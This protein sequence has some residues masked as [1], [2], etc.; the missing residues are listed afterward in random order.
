MKEIFN[1]QG[2]CLFKT[3]PSYFLSEEEKHYI[4]NLEYNNTDNIH[5]ISKNVNILNNPLCDNLNN[6]LN[7]YANYYIKN[8]LEIDHKLKQLNSWVTINKKGGY[9]PIHNHTNTFISVCFYP[10][11]DKGGISFESIPPLQNKTNLTFKEI[12]ANVFNSNKLTLHFSS[13]DLIIF[14]GWLDHSGEIND[15]NIDR[16]MIG[17]NYFISGNVGTPEDVNELKLL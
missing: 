7:F 11:A 1:F 5:F 6:M 4:F 8:I 15:S 12:N 13:G 9:H 10:Q 2:N 3:N 17:V 14:P 16:I